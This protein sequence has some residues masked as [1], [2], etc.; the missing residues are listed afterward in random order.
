VLEQTNQ[1]QNTRVVFTSD[2]GLAVGQHGFFDKH[3]PYQANVAAPL[4]VSMPGTLPGGAVSEAVVSGVDLIP[5]FL[6]FARIPLPRPMHGHDLTP[7]WKNPAAE[8]P[9]PDP[10]RGSPPR[11]RTPAPASAFEHSVASCGGRPGRSP[12]VWG[13]GLSVGVRWRTLGAVG[14]GGFWGFLQRIRR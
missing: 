7:V 4:I 14:A 8:W 1:R 2:Q 12:C 5:T 13:G 11:T 9:K 6:G 3:A 10:V